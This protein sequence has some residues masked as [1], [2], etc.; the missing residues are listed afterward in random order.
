MTG[1]DSVQTCQETDR[2]A[3]FEIDGV[4]FKVNSLADQEKLGVKTRQPRWLIAYKFPARQ[5]T[6]KLL[7]VK[8]QV[9]RTGIVTPVAVL[10]PVPISGVTVS[11]A[12]LHNE[13]YY[14]QKD[15]HIGDWVLVERAGDVIPKV[16]KPIVE[17]RSGEEREIEMPRFCPSCQTELEKEG[18][19]YYCP[20]LNCPA[21][22]KGHL[23]H[24]VSKRAFN[25]DG[26]GE[27]IIDQ[28][29]QEKLLTSP[30]DLFYLQ[31]ES[32]R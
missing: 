16:V 12:T 30:A 20:N 19:Y 29:M 23:L 4:V 31:K 14:R 10:Q 28:L 27:E 11:S 25:I 21:Q 24:L 8:F 7:D 2:R 1:I 32:C 13:D 5:E 17:K 26:L 3:L 9:G 15:I 18:A 6:T 22:L